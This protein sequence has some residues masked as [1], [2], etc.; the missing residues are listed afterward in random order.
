MNCRGF[1]FVELMVSVGVASV[2][3]ASLAGTGMIIGSASDRQAVQ[4]ALAID[5]EFALGRIEQAITRSERLLV[6]LHDRSFTEFTEHIRE[7][8]VPAQAPPAGSTFATAALAVAQDPEIDLDYDGIADADNDG[9]GRVDEDWSSDITNDGKT[10]VVGIDDDGDGEV[11]ESDFGSGDDDELFTLEEDPVNG[12][13]DDGDG[14]IDEDPWSDMNADNRAGIAGIDDDR[15]GAIDE[16][17]NNDD[18]EDGLSNEDWLDARVFFINDS[19]LIERIPVPWDENGDLSITGNDYVES[20][21]TSNVS[22]FGIRLLS[23]AQDDP[24][25]LEITLS[26]SDASGQMLTRSARLRLGA[27]L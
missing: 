23:D 3:L 6:P 4:R 1:T 15:D 12:V 13:D 5:A 16:G 26:L 17:N 24:Q 20:I 7:Q 8:F 18:D 19:D 22:F 11:D 2:L 27:N 10:G 25:L 21:V 9:D 14:S